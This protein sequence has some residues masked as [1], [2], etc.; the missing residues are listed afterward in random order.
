MSHREQIIIGIDPDTDRN[1]IAMLDMSTHKLQVQMLAF[2]S[3]LDFIKEKY[4]QF[5][6]IDNG[7]SRSSSRQDG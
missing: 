1:G 7:T 2:P 4:H 6:E 5:A 3:L